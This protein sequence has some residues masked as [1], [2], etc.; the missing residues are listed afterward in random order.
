MNKLSFNFSTYGYLSTTP[1]LVN[2]MM[3][4]FAADF[5]TG[6][7]I[8]LG[9]G[10]VSEDVIPR[11]L[12]REAQEIILKDSRK[13]PNILN[14]GASSGTD[15]L[16]QSIRN[17][18]LS[19]KLGDLTKEILNKK[20]IVIGANGATSLLESI[21]NLLKPGLVITSDPIYYIYSNFLKRKGFQVVAIPE[22][23]QGIC[24][25]RLQELVNQNRIDIGEVSF[26]YIVTV[27]NPT[28]T[29]LSDNRCQELVEFA[30]KQSVKL[31][32]YIPVFFDRAYD[33]IIHNPKCK[34]P[35]SGFHFD[36]LG[37]VYEIGSLSKV[38]APGIRIGYLIGN[39]H[40]LLSGIVQ[41]TSDIGF[42]ASP[43][44]QQ[45]ASYLLNH[46][47]NAIVES[48]K[49]L[50][51]YKAKHIRHCLENYLDSNL[52]KITGGDAGFYYYLTLNQIRT[53][54][55]SKFY[56]FLTRT[57]GNSKIDG[58]EVKKH[59]RV[60]YIPGTYYVYQNGE[61]FNESK[62]QLRL[63]YGYSS[64]KEI[65]RALK[66]IVDAIEWIRDSPAKNRDSRV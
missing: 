61:L 15:E 63:S 52:K 22:D 6:I 45:I 34:S 19:T 46:H 11:A 50:Y 60:V 13:Y 39:P 41:R 28:C 27:N 49:Q 59:P 62:T 7:D 47:G 31:G 57:T 10:Y 44:N 3:A 2:R 65:G 21:A 12:I 26:L 38:I 53:D 17:F 54:P 33:P 40:E 16:I 43:I 1:S 18:I 4:S 30:T 24:V 56:K 37:L 23:D 9:V 14:Y 35:V 25:P 29:I 5:R 20:Q 8:N 58:S 32:R 48:A 51:Q 55:E 64:L 66:I 36:E 42:S